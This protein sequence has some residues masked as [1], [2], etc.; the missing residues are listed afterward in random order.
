MHQPAPVPFA[1]DDLDDSSLQIDIVSFQRGKLS[2]PQPNP[3]QHQPHGVRTAGL[4]PFDIRANRQVDGVAAEP[5]STG[6]SPRAAPGRDA[7]PQ[8]T[9]MSAFRAPASPAC[10][11]SESGHP[12]SHR[13]RARRVR[14]WPDATPAQGERVEDGVVIRVSN[15]TVPHPGPYLKPPSNPRSSV[16]SPCH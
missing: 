14:A 15:K 3:V 7:P 2:T 8:I 9:Q 4:Q 16:P 5:G 12:R 6:S 11:L 13:K 1:V 10:Q